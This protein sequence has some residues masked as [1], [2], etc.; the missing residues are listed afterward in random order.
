MYE[1][2]IPGGLMV[3]SKVRRKYL[4]DNTWSG[5]LKMKGDQMSDKALTR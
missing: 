3:G 5:T 1:K 4:V 2:V